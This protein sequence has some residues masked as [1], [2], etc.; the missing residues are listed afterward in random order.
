MND[1]YKVSV[2]D[3][4]Q[5][6]I[7]K[8]TVSELDSI[9]TG[10]N[11]FHILQGNIPFTAEIIHSDFLQK[12][13]TVKVNNNLYTVSISDNLDLLIHELGFEVGIAK[14][15]NY[16]KAPMPGLILEINVSEGQS[17]K[18]NQ[19]LI[20]LGAMKME[21]SIL[22]PREGIIKSVSV[23][24]GQSVEKGQLLIEFQ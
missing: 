23:A 11:K 21:N 6:D 17:V 14:E 8:K 4:F 15:V 5:F 16:I 19:N 18:E 10:N 3:S 22:S 24:I 20:V 1:S 12:K 7:E 2:N 9:I 13:Y